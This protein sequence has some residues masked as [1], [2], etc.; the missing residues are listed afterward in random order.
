MKSPP[1]VRPF[2]FTLVELLAV[3]AII[4]VLASVLFP[5]LGQ[6]RQ[7]ASCATLVSNYRQIGVAMNMYV[8][9]NHG[10]LPGIRDDNTSYDLL[11]GQMPYRIDQSSQERTAIQGP[12]DLGPYLASALVPVGQANYYY[13][14]VLDCPVMKSRYPPAQAVTLKSTLLAKTVALGGTSELAYPFGL[15]SPVQNAMLLNGL[16]AALPTSTRWVLHDCEPN[17]NNGPIH[18]ANYVTLFFD[19]HVSLV[20][21]TRMG[22]N[23]LVN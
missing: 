15:K 7:S 16:S 9:D 18:G 12:D 13:T 14:P 3:V 20:P 19:G 5:V 1:L 17:Q 10:R 2:G 4:G 8:A 11:G 6:V 23:G 22:A 21:Q